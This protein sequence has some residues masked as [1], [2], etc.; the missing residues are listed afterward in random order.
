MEAAS[1]PRTPSVP[2]GEKVRAFISTYGLIAI[3]AA[4]PVAFGIR[5]LV[6]DGNLVSSRNPDDLPAFG[7]KL[8]EA[9]AASA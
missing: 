9:I 8:V 4:L 5:D 3:L 6:V 2:L 1:V 7:A